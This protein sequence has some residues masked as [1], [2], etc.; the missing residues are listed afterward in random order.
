MDDGVNKTLDGFVS[1]YIERDQTEDFYE[2]LSNR[3]QQE[4]PD[5]P[6]DE[7]EKLSK[8]II[9]G[10]ARYDLT[11]AD[12]NK[13]VEAGQSK[14][15]WL[16]EN[17]TGIC[18]DMPINEVG[19]KLQR[20]Y[21]EMIAANAALMDEPVDA[22]M[23][24]YAEAAEWN[25]YSVKDKALN[26]GKQAVMTGLGVAANAIKLNMENGES[27]NGEIIG[28][29][30]Q[31][32]ATSGEV[33]AVVAGAIKTAAENKLTNAL[34]DNTPIETI[35]DI[36]G[37]AVEGA[38]AMFD[39]STGKSTVTEALD[40]TGR[41]SVAVASHLCANF[42]QRAAFTIPVVGPFVAFLANGLFEHMRAPQFTENVYTVVRSAAISTWEGIKEKAS[43]IKNFFTNKVSNWLFNG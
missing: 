39:V 9:E 22:V 6:S 8:E 40:R 17:V 35:C 21:G 14:E 33:K 34:P 3:I 36:A 24:D 16:A 25:E 4:I 27:I 32:G 42:L 13:A 43:G 10:V 20:V 18:A 37:V 38:E 2:W 12:I 29:A 19:D 11:L 5:L 41:A 30:L 23:V 28:L 1:S 26:I 31:E 15:E 7:S